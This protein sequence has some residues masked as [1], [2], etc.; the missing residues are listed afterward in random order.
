MNQGVNTPLILDDVPIIEI[1]TST[2]NV[3]NIN[4]IA[5]VYKGFRQ[6]SKEP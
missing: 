3:E 1:S 2:Y 6:E 4:S 5:N